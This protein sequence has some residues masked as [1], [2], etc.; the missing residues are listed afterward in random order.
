MSDSQFDEIFKNRLHGHESSIPDD[1]WERIIQKKDKDRKGFFFFFKLSGLFLLG[2]GIGY[3]LLFGINKKT[4]E[5]QKNS[6]AKE[7]TVPATANAKSIDTN[8]KET[9]VPTTTGAKSIDPG[10][11]KAPSVR[12]ET[13]QESIYSV[14]KKYQDKSYASSAIANK[15]K[16]AGISSSK[17]KRNSAVQIREEALTADISNQ[18]DQ[19][20]NSTTSANSETLNTDTANRAALKK[21]EPSLAAGTAVKPLAKKSEPL[22]AADTATKPSVKKQDTAKKT[23]GEKW[24]LDLYSSPDYPIVY[25]EPWITTKLSYTAGLRVNR[26]FGPHFSGRTG[27]QFSQINFNFSDSNGFPTSYHLKSLD[28]P[29]LAGYSW[30]NKTLGMTIN[31]GV[32]VNLYTWPPEDQINYFKTNTGLSLYLGLN[33]KKQINDRLDIF[34]EPYYRY[35]LSSM[36]VSTV[37]YAK[38]IDVAGLSFG[39]R[40]HFKK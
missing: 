35:R 37:Y 25:G 13:A 20:A 39:V 32:V 16:P 18:A 34:T 2:F 12:N 14:Q 6:V 38:F 7:I 27:I 30:G 28:L 17:S 11:A 4:P 33:V 3:I 1:M 8:S 31:A 5:G 10:P 22:L 26:S 29:V 36:T 40:Y 21:A 15:N 24:S 23:T 19:K 9:A